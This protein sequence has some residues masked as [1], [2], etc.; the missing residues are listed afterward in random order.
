VT[1]YSFVALTD[2]EWY[3]S[4]I[5][6]THVHTM[7][8]QMMLLALAIRASILRFSDEVSAV[9][10]LKDTQEEERLKVLY[11]KYLSFYNRLYFKE[12]THQDQGIELY[13]MAL[14]QLK[15]PEHIAKLDGK[16][17]KLF[18]LA[19]LKGDART[20]KRMNRLT[21]MGALFVFPSFIASLLGLDKIKDLFAQPHWQWIVLSAITGLVVAFIINKGGKQ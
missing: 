20:A 2:T 19:N 16:F 10:T 7:Y 21:Y 9:A 4:E 15:I 8:F 6:R 17:V 13:D 5:V 1:R 3:G 14:K 18:D 12:V 11:E